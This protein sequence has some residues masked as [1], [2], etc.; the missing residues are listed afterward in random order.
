M[1]HI[2]PSIQLKKAASR[3]LYKLERKV[4]D[5]KEDRSFGGFFKRLVEQ[6]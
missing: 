5:D 6:F 3:L 4:L 1:P 2:S